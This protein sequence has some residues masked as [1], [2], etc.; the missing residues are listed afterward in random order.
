MDGGIEFHECAKRRGRIGLL[1]L[2]VKRFVL[3]PR[4]VDVISEFRF[5]Y[6]CFMY[7]SKMMVCMHVLC[8]A[9]E[10]GR[11]KV[12]ELERSL[13]RCSEYQAAFE[14]LYALTSFIA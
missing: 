1:L 12:D 14:S 13:H 11:T 7:K 6:L 2:G 10:R 3:P 5:A 4:S 8:I 9:Y